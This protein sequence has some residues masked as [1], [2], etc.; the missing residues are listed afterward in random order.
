M[1]KKVKPVEEVKEEQNK[2]LIIVSST[3]IP[4]ANSIAAEMSKL[5][6]DKLFI[7]AAEDTA[8]AL[9]TSLAGEISSEAILEN[10]ENEMKAFFSDPANIKMATE[11]AVLWGEMLGFGK[12]YKILKAVSILNVPHD[13]LIEEINVLAEFGFI[14]FEP[15]TKGKSFAIIVDNQARQRV[16]LSELNI[17]LKAVIGFNN[18]VKSL[19]PK[20]DS[21]M[22]DVVL[23]RY[24]AQQTNTL[25]L[26]DVS[27]LQSETD[28]NNSTEKAGNTKPKPKN[29]SSKQ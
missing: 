21:E 18:K 3:D 22:A 16:F 23:L 15:N 24:F 29:R 19:Y 2:P 27:K 4:L 17:A 10:V 20:E 5:H 6:P 14:V 1:A 7:I 25:H 28:E 11:K 8:K 9:E 12:Y 26:L 13:Q